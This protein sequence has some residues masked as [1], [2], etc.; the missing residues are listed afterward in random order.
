[1][2]RFNHKVVRLVQ[3]DNEIWTGWHA[4]LQTMLNDMGGQGWQLIS[5]TGC[6]YIFQ[7]EL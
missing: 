2:K 4:R 6:D 1:M 5:V 7:R 3:A